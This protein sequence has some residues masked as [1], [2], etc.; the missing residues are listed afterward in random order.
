M[1]IN[2]RNKGERS[3]SKLDGLSLKCPRC[4]A[5]GSVGLRNI[6]DNRGEKVVFICNKCGDQLKIE[7]CKLMMYF[8]LIAQGMG[9]IRSEE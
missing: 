8:L 1:P 2:S 4:E 3:V 5:I 7:K 9:K 6:S